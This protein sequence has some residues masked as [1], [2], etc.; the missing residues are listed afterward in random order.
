MSESDARGLYPTTIT[1]GVSIAAGLCYLLE[2]IV[3]VGEGGERRILEIKI[4]DMVQGKPE[5]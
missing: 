4:W 3:D 5:E 1:V 2:I